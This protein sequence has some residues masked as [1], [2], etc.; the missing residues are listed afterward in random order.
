[1]RIRRH[2]RPLAPLQDHIREALVL[3]VPWPPATC[4]ND[5]VCWMLV[6]NRG[7]VPLNSWDLLRQSSSF[8]GHAT[9]QAAS[10]WSSGGRCVGSAARSGTSWTCRPLGSHHRAGMAPRHARPGPPRQCCHILWP[11]PG[12]AKSFLGFAAQA[13]VAALLDSGGFDQEQHPFDES[14]IWQRLSWTS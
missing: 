1:M 9:H 4:A 12:D 6:I 10:W 14:R 5:K 2:L 13:K 11:A 8:A 3:I 7:A